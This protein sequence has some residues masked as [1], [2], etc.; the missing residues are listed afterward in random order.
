MNTFIFND[1]YPGSKLCDSVDLDPTKGC[2]PIDCQMKY[3]GTRSYFNKRWKRC[4]KVPKCVYDPEKLL[5]DVVSG[6]IE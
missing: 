1:R 6:L 5:P 4:Q 3:L 2:T